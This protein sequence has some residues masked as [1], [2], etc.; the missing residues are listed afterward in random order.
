V[1][2]GI[3]PDGVRHAEFFG[4]AGTDVDLDEVLFPEE[5]AV[6]ARA[7]DKR[8]REFAVVRVAARRALAELGHPAAPILPG[9][10]GAPQWPA[11][12][13]GSM[14][15]CEGYQAAVVARAD[16]FA[17]IG[18]DAEPDLPLPDGVLRLVSL[19]D[20]QVA[21]S[22]LAEK[23]PAVNWDRLLFCAKEAVYKTWFPLT[24]QWL[25]F[26][27]ALVDLRPD[28]TFSALLQVPGPMVGATRLDGFE[29]RWL[30][31]D[32]LIVTA[33]AQSAR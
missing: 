14:T 31:S 4:G 17:S 23:Q 24:L 29:G 16:G 12:V 6:V 18:I 32:G 15:H 26:A 19:P 27:E 21:L 30:A 33:I 10:R 5:A 28:G 7:V 25:D 8:R 20:E 13:V 22:D 11:G 9:E 1:I 2:G 3:L